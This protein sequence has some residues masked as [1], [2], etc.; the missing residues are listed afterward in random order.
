MELHYFMELHYSQNI[1]YF[2]I[3]E[4]KADWDIAANI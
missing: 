2:T 3:S 1:F 4:D